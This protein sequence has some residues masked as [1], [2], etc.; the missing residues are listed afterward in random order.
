MRRRVVL[1]ES[2]DA[3]PTAAVS[4]RPPSQSPLIPARR[5]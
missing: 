3:C 4:L 2:C 5:Q 1:E